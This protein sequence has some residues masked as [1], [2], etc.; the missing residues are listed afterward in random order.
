M[1]EKKIHYD[2]TS[3]KPNE[4]EYTRTLCGIKNDKLMFEST[5]K[6]DEVNCKKCLAILDKQRF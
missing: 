1:N 3:R 4:K 2:W 6:R 5:L